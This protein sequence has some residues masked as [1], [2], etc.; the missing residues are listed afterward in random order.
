MKIAVGVGKNLAIVKAA[1]KVDFEVILTKSEDE[2][3]D[4]V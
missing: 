1:Q 3:L 2:L 4:L